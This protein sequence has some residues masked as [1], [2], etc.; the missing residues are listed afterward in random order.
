MLLKGRQNVPKVTFG[1][2][3]LKVIMLEVLDDI[4]NLNEILETKYTCF[5]CH[6]QSHSYY[7][8]GEYKVCY[9]IFC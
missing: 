1:D 2:K 5:R 8:Q 7:I 6:T 3:Q 4:I 9:T